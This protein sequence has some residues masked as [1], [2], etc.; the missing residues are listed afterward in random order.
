MKLTEIRLKKVLRFSFLQLHFL[1]CSATC[2][3]CVGIQDVRIP[4]MQSELHTF[5][6]GENKFTETEF[7]YISQ[8]QAL[9]S[10]QECGTSYFSCR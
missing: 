5:I 2:K 3:F 10:A 1:M 4:C 6:I 7:R 8:R 9:H